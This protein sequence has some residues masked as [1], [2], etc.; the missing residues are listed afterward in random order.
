MKGDHK[1]HEKNKIFLEVYVFTNF[2]LD[3]ARLLTQGQVR[4]CAKYQKSNVHN[5]SLSG[6]KSRQ[7]ILFFREEILVSNLL[8]KSTPLLDFVKILHIAVPT[9][10]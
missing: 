1:I 3:D 5:H 7:K 10:R 8:K 6:N 4:G 9:F 2:Q